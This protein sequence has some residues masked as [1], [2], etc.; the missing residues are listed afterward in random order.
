MRMKSAQQQASSKTN[1]FDENIK[2]I[3]TKNVQNYPY[4]KDYI[5]LY[6]INGRFT[7]SKK[8][9]YKNEEPDKEYGCANKTAKLKGSSMDLQ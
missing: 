9:A 6:Q 7:S 5:Q 4:R 1:R 2:P 8:N 3:K